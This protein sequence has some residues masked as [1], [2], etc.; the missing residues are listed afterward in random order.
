ME[1]NG[2]RFVFACCSLEAVAKEELEAEPEPELEPEPEQELEPEPE[3]GPEPEQELEP[4]DAAFID[5]MTEAQ[6]ALRLNKKK[7]TYENW[8]S[9]NGNVKI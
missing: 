2:A 4:D 1:R 7:S 3:L 8:R 9:L 5:L 6:T